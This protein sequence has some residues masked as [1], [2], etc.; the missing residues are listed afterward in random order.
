MESA[1]WNTFSLTGEGWWKAQEWLN[2]REWE[3]KQECF[4]GPKKSR[5]SEITYFFVEK[6][7]FILLCLIRLPSTEVVLEKQDYLVQE[8]MV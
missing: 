1:V 6:V 3:L 2:Y 8:Q 5:L 4:F 7:A